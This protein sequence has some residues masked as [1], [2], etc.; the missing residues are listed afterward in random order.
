MKKI[1]AIIVA[2]MMLVGS[3]FAEDIVVFEPGVTPAKGGQVVEVNGESYFKLK[4]FGY[5]T[6]FKIPEVDLNGCTEFEASA[7]VEKENLKYQVVISIKDGNF[8]DISN[9][10]IK[11]LKVEKQTGVAEH[12]IQQSWNKLS[13]TNVAGIIQPMVQDAEAPFNP[14]NYTIYIGKVIARKK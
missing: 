9:P 12:E 2:M 14:H 8:G 5:D 11:G 13:K 7:Y 10:T 4:C 6:S 1:S 3:I